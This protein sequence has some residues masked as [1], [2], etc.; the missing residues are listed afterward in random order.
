MIGLELLQLLHQL[1]EFSVADLGL[2]GDVITLFVI[3]DLPTELG[4]AGGGSQS[5]AS[6][7]PETT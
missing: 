2:V 1:I 3:A 7:I 5:T 6:A 4:D